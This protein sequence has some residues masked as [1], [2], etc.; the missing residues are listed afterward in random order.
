MYLYI[1]NGGTVRCSPMTVF[2]FHSQDLGPTISY[3]DNRLCLVVVSWY[4][5][6]ACG[7]DAVQSTGCTLTSANGQSFDLTGLSADLMQVNRT[8]PDK[9]NYTYA[10]QLCTGDRVNT[11]CGILDLN[12]VRVA[13]IDYQNHG[14]C[15]SLGGGMGNSDMPTVHS[16]SPTKWVKVVTPISTGRP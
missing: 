8:S 5:Y 7:T 4:T 2:L 12:E 9:H 6:Y 1:E 16:H 13:Q 14:V 15:R 10:I 3:L 11:Q